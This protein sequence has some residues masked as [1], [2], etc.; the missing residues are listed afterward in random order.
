M[1]GDFKKVP[2]REIW[3]HEASDFTPWLASN[4]TELGTALGLEL[5]LIESE[6]SVGDFSLDLLVKDLGSNKTVI[7]ENQL[8]KTDHDHLGKLLTYA[9]GHNASIVIWLSES[10][11]DEHRQAL[12][13]LNQR[14]DNVTNFF[15]VVVEVIKIDDS[16][17]A[18][19]FKI[20]A[21]PNEWQKSKTSASG[22]I[23]ISSKGEKYRNYFQ[24]LIDELRENHRFT[25]ARAGQPQNW[26]SFSS[27][28]TG[29]TYGANFCQG[30]KAR[31]E[32]YID[33]GD[34]E[35]NK[36]IFEV[37]LLQKVEIEQQVGSSI[38][39]EKLEDKRASRLALY[40]D[41]SI[42]DSDSELELVKAW[43][44]ET[45]L[46]FKECFSIRVREIL[47]TINNVTNQ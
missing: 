43:H 27:G 22:R 34:Q 40:M 29:I 18:F 8:T 28:N 32:L 17:P 21:S 11:R 19:N 15:G 35:K 41:G 1:F 42:E 30:G 36:E 5:E 37:L 47:Q 10:I 14:T 4:I 45:L 16:R 12:D 20:V 26:Y 33:V 38:S 23:S 9:A 7:V 39:W 46:K 24:K 2:L 3:A 6:A 31:S 25:S 13:W 44:I